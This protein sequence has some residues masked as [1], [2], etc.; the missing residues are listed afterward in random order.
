[1]HISRQPIEVESIE[2]WYSHFLNGYL[3]SK[4]L[5]MIKDI[6]KPFWGYRY[7]VLGGDDQT[8][9]DEL[10]NIP[11]RVTLQTS[12]IAGKTSLCSTYDALPFQSDTFD[13]IVAPHVLEYQRDAKQSLEELCRVLLPEGHLVITGFN[14]V[15][16]WGFPWLRQRNKGVRPWGGNFHSLN[17]L[18]GW[19]AAFG[20]ETIE[21][22][23]YLYLPPS[24]GEKNYQRLRSFELFCQVCWPQWG[25]C[26][27]VVAR[28]KVSTLTPIK[29]RWRSKQLLREE[30]VIETT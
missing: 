16:L 23:S 30:G 5:K 13:L 22:K 20:C 24:V 11:H 21:V 15:S 8:P 29:P 4:E 14:P 10:S 12:Y 26:Y 19:L 2:N 6:I 27:C 18:R 7:L 3:A 25:G 1:M 17:R 9:W 28:K